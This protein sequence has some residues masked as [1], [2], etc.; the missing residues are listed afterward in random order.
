MD[1]ID[2]FTPFQMVE[3]ST[4]ICDTRLGDHQS[5]DSPMSWQ[6]IKKQYA[7]VTYYARLQ[8]IVYSP[9]YPAVQ[10]VEL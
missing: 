1:R 6:M 2:G 5:I 9:V 7:A 10:P 3:M 4:A 8:P